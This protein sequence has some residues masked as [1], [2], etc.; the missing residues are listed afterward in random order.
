MVF[1]IA[2]MSLKYAN[3]FNLPNL[4]EENKQNDKFIIDAIMYFD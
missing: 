4:Y 3:L 1:L 2:E